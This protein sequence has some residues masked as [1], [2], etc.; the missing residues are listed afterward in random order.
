MDERFDH[1]ELPFYP[2]SYER[3]KRKVTMRLK[4][5]TDEEKK[6][7]FDIQVQRFADIKESFVRDKPRYRE[8]LDPNLI[9]KLEINQSVDEETLRQ[10]LKRMNNEY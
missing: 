6:K 7:F 5:R 9:F 4:P 3:E 2:D 8:Y 1:L 10:E